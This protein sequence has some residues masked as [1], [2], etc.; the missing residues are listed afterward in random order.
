MAKQIAL[1]LTINGVKQNIKS[2][3][4]L[5]SAISSAQEELK[6]MEIGSE[7]FKKLTRE[8]NQAKSA[9]K[10]FEKSFEGQDIEQRIGAFAKLGEG[11][12][13]SFA[14]AQAAV[15]LFGNESEDVAKAAA[16][17]QQL[18]TVA[19]GARSVAESV[20]Q[21][22][23]VASTIAT[24]ASA[25]AARAAT[26][27]TRTLYTTLAA[28]PYGAILAVVGLLI[29]AIVT[30]TSEQEEQVNIQK[31]LASA[32]S[33]EAD[34]LREQLSVLNSG[35]GL[36]N[37]QKKAIEDLK[38][39]YPGFNAFL[40]E[41]NRLNREGQKFLEN[42][43][44]LYELE[45]QA[46]LL[47]QKISESNIKILELENTNI[48]EFESI[49]DSDKIG[50]AYKRRQKE[51][52]DIRDTQE[53]YRQNLIELKKEINTLT[54]EI[55]KS[56]KVLEDNAKKEDDAKKKADEATKAKEK[57]EEQQKRLNEAYS[58]GLLAVSTYTQALDEYTEAN[59]RYDEQIK[60]ILQSD[61]TTDILKQLE[62]IK[63]LRI[64]SI[65]QLQ[66]AG[67]EF[68]Q[69]INRLSNVPTDAFIN[70]FG[71]FRTRLQEEFKNG[72]NNFNEITKEFI[73][74]QKDLTQEQQEELLRLSQAYTL[75]SDQ[76]KNTVGF[77]LVVESLKDFKT[78][79]GE[80]VSGYEAL[81]TLFE[82]SAQELGILKKEFDEFGNIT[83]V[84]FDPIKAGENADKLFDTI[85]NKLLIPTQIEFNKQEIERR[86]RDIQVQQDIINNIKA[87]ESQK[88]T[89]AI[90]IQELKGQIDSLTL[91]LT[92]L[93]NVATSD[94]ALQKG[95]ISKEV[96]Q[97]VDA[98]TQSILNNA[99]AITQVEQKYISLIGEVQ[100]L[101]SELTD[102]Q[103]GKAVAGELLK[104]IDFV[105]NL[106]IG[107]RTKA[108]QEELKF[109]EEVKKDE[110]GLLDFRQKLIDQNIDITKTSY[111][112][113][114]TLYIE[115]R[116]RE[117]KA[118]KDADA[119]EE[120][121]RNKRF[122]EI[123][124]KF[125]QTSQ[126]VG[127]I[128]EIVSTESQAQ[129]EKI[130]LDQKLALEQVVG[131]SQ[132]AAN[133]RLE[134]E[135]EYNDRRKKVEKQAQITGLKLTY[136]Q[137]VAN[138][139]AAT[140]RAFAD[141]GPI[142]GPIFAALNAVLLGA[143]L[144]SI[145]NQISTIQSLRRGGLIKQKT[146]AGGMLLSGPSHEDGGIPLAQFGVIAEGQEAIINRQSTVNFRD[147]LSTINQSGGGRPLV[148]N[149]FDDSRIV[150]AI[151]SQKQM[152]LRAYVLQSEITNE[153][154]ISKRLDDL[155]KI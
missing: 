80:S 89:A 62:E 115:Y 70:T 17:A 63:N 122:E 25:A 87:T 105:S 117:L 94:E 54:G 125:D 95:L 58:K 34:A 71:E 21:V 7:S 144:I 64:E 97:V 141:L 112:D 111:D 4:D 100:K 85:K 27:A 132:E 133:K 120:R 40:D 59:K 65:K 135:K 22:R 109:I 129:I 48:E 46:K 29:T 90:A 35:N 148:N 68:F 116:R 113:L 31:E 5:E 15:A 76:I 8:I 79:T 81:T 84:I 152:P 83:N 96:K 143:Q 38:K 147:L 30:L 43:I 6:E 19:L 103:F 61:Y 9:F 33:A 126:F 128:N 20:V 124:K 136:A 10:D 118:G 93:N 26:T 155:S 140:V 134:I 146:A 92:E 18:L 86:K 107:A 42:K 2:I 110:A 150:E 37:L 145:Q 137:T 123:A 39:E 88:E 57:Q 67:D 53:L 75:L 154:A 55:D 151:N 50:G 45:A 49:W 74:N 16:T 52:D 11:I 114:L 142:A 153:Q 28:N 73:K 13:A 102:E 60:K 78:A 3:K 24:A 99:L 66:T 12:T 121:E 72:T 101:R 23:T 77:D 51:I 119:E 127:K 138:T 14:T 130:A 108:Q 106:L 98:N 131:D 32:T 82:E 47:V 56:N 1:N 36:R 104:N 44:K 139:A 149:T 91:G 41:E 69:T